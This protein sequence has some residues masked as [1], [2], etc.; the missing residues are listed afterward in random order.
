MPSGL[1]HGKCQRSFIPNRYIRECSARKLS[2]P[3]VTAFNLGGHLETKS[4]NVKKQIIYIL[5]NFVFKTFDS[6]SGTR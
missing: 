1:R 2:E 5:L 3:M 4:C 6:Q